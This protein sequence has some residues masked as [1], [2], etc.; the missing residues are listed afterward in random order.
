M[1]TMRKLSNA[2][3]SGLIPDPETIVTF[4]QNVLREQWNDQSTLTLSI[5]I[6][7][8]QGNDNNDGFSWPNAKKTLSATQQIIP[9][10]LRGITVFIFLHPGTYIED[11]LTFNHINGV[12]RFCWVGTFI[13]TANTAYATFVKNGTSN[14]VR[15]NDQVIIKLKQALG[16]FS[17]SRSCLYGIHQQDFNLGY[18]QP[19]FCYWDKFVIAKASA[20]EGGIATCLLVISNSTLSSDSGYTLDGSTIDNVPEFINSWGN[21][22]IV[23]N[24]IRAIGGNTGGSQGLGVWRGI[25]LASDKDDIFFKAYTIAYAT[26]YEP[27]SGKQWEII[28][29][30]QFC[31]SGPYAVNFKIDLPTNKID[32]TPGITGLTA[33]IIYLDSLSSGSI[34]TNQTQLSLNDNSTA[35]HSV[36]NYADSSTKNIVSPNIIDVSNSTTIKTKNAVP[37]DAVLSNEFATFYLDQTT[38]KLKVKLKYS[39]GT[40]KTG[41]IALV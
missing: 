41:E 25:I 33:P 21:S 14:P 10:D 39:N 30:K 5:Y 22:Y 4:P 6:D 28:N 18:D 27:L 31:T 19:G 7:A 2:L 29:Y 40:V 16:L 13:N 12:I 8:Q 37:A 20:A 3:T 11:S 35:N 17:S 32:F 1:K 38:N 26:G 23:I 9:Y 34:K 24:A 15:N 36:T